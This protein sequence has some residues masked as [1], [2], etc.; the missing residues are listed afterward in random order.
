MDQ[1]YV[2]SE[3]ERA[4]YPKFY[5]EMLDR[6]ANAQ[7]VL[8]RR[9][10][11]SGRWDKQRIRVAKLHEKVVNQRKNFLH[12]RS[13]ELATHFDVVAIEDLNIG[14]DY[15]KHFILEK[16]SLIM[17]GVCSLFSELIN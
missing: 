13:K 3:D 11:G 15:R 9:T 1:L 8:S 4:N 5:R 17:L 2:S 12:H 7:R 6:L 16:A 14:R 10:K